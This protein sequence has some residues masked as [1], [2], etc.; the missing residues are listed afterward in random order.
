MKDRV[1]GM[2]VFLKPGERILAIDERA[3]F[4]IEALEYTETL[5]ACKLILATLSRLKPETLSSDLQDARWGVLYVGL[6]VKAWER[7]AHEQV[8]QFLKG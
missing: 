4:P 5:E 7:W 2:R 6:K 8:R 3:P 1:I